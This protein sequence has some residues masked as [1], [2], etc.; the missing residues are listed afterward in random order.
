[1]VSTVFVI[2]AIS[3]ISH[4]DFSIV[5]LLLH[6]PLAMRLKKSSPG[7]RYLNACV[8]HHKLISHLF[9]LLHDDLPHGLDVVD[10]V[11]EGTD[12]LNILD[13]QNSVSGVAEIFHI[14]SHALII[15]LSDG[16]ESLSSR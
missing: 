3:P 10:S 7:F 13:V 9:G 14:V 6:G 11:M 16:L 2:L 5:L 4:V 8:S 1:V 12:D 15:L